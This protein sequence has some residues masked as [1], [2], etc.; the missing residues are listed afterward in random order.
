MIGEHEQ[1]ELTEPGPGSFSERRKMRDALG[2]IVGTNRYGGHRCK[3]S[4]CGDVH[5]TKKATNQGLTENV[6]D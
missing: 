5:W 6:N 1:T 4:E 3:C 2:D